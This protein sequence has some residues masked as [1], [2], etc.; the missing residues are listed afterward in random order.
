MDSHWDFFPTISPVQ[1]NRIKISW[2]NWFWRTYVQSCRIALI[3]WKW[4]MHNCSRWH[5]RSMKQM[6][7]LPTL[8]VVVIVVVCFIGRLKNRNSNHISNEFHFYRLEIIMAILFG[9]HTNSIHCVWLNSKCR[10]N[11]NE[12]W[13]KN[14]SSVCL[15][16]CVCVYVFVCDV[17]N[18]D[19][20][21]SVR[22]DVVVPTSAVLP[23]FILLAFDYISA[24]VL[25]ICMENTHGKNNDP[26]CETYNSKHGSRRQ[27][28]C[29]SFR[30]LLLLLSF[31]YVPTPTATHRVKLFSHRFGR[32]FVLHS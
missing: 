13:K 30:I 14:D 20:R 12:I 27:C 4:K 8:S 5:R 19:A 16:V 6:Q 2:R 9:A 32:H 10:W 15:H 7:T 23:P 21:A 22:F 26:K 29:F 1:L 18:I 31:W 25:Y 24:F 3:Y 28:C 17:N 11:E